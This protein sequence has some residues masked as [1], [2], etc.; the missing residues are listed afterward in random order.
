MITFV[1]E[2]KMQLHTLGQ[3][4]KKHWGLILPD[5]L[6]QSLVIQQ[7]KEAASER[8]ARKCRVILEEAIEG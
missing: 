4:P 7:K 5:V 8:K 3:Q 2:A 1:L 6:L